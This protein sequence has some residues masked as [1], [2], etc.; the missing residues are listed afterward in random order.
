MVTG[1]ESPPTLNTELVVFAA[2]TV[3][4]APLAVRLPDAV[5]LVPTTTLPKSSLAGLTTSCPEAVVV[6]VPESVRLS[7]LLDAL[8]AMVTVALKVP[9][10]LGANLMLI[11]V[12]CPA[13]TVTGRVGAIKEK[14]GLEIETLLMV[15][16]AGPEFVAVADRVLLLPAATLPKSRVVDCRERVLCWLEEPPLTPWQPIR[17]VRPARRSNAPAAFP[18]RFEQTVLAAVVSILSQAAASLDFRHCSR[19]S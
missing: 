11:V 1:S 9:A 4:L 17:E 18:R 6:P 2:E 15:T 10:A 14:Y 8:L 16:E 19:T 12:L 3:T 7:V 5:P 13:A